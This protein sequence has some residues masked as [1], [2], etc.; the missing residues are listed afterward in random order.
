M[1]R[2]YLLPVL[3][4]LAWSAYAVASWGP[5]GCAPSGPVG[6]ISP[7][8]SVPSQV[9]EWR[10]PADDPGR[11]YLYVNDRLVGGYCTRLG[12]YLA[13][14]AAAGDWAKKPGGVLYDWKTPPDDLPAKYHQT[15]SAIPKRPCPHCYIPNDCNCG[16]GCTCTSGKQCQ[17]DCTC[18]SRRALTDGPNF[19]LEQQ[20][21]SGRERCLRGRVE[22]APESGL[23]AI[24][25]GVPDWA[26]KDW[27]LIISADPDLRRRVREEILSHPEATQLRQDTIVRSYPPDH[28]HLT[29][30]KTRVPGFVTNGTPT[31]YL[32]SKDGKV[33]H[34]QQ[35]YNGGVGHVL[36]AFRRSRSDYDPA[37]DP[38]LRKVTPT[39]PDLNK[40][41]TSWLVVGG[42]S[43]LVLTLLF[44]KGN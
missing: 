37:K 27:L 9:R 28:W 19:G 24:Q 29:D 33:L 3:A 36:A 14:D 38:D 21:L 5:G 4:A 42:L 16:D 17:P 20:A 15:P 34:R 12:L 6:S 10:E 13:W 7:Y 32:L 25:E 2:F 41:P 35:D 8:A 1:K 44:K 23:Q 26:S 40:I 30:L 39:L 31:I 11:V 22:I 43:L 18:G